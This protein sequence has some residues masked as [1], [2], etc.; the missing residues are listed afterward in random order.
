MSSKIQIINFALRLIK[1]S[2]IIDLA[3]QNE[4]ARVASDMYELTRQNIF[5]MCDWNCLRKRATLTKSTEP[6]AFGFDYQYILPA[7]CLRVIGIQEP[8]TGFFVPYFH[9]VFPDDMPRELTYTVEGRMLLTN[10]E[11]DVNILY[12]SDVVDTTRY[13]SMLVNAF[14]YMLALNMAIPLSADSTLA[15]AIESKLNFF[16]K[17]AKAKNALATNYPTETTMF[18]RRRYPW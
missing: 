7:D 10:R 5:E 16:L 11:E 18:V 1:Q 9:G 17:A 4:R 12:I 14:A 15:G 2:P 6:P 13:D 3:D 8:D